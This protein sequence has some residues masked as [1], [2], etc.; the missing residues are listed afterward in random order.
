MVV[1]WKKLKKK[2]EKCSTFKKYFFWGLIQMSRRNIA[3]GI[4]IGTYQTK[5]VVVEANPKG[6]PT[7][8]GVGLSESKG[9]RHGYITNIQDAA[10]SI[11]AAISE[12]E[13]TS[14]LE[15]KEAYFSI[16][17]IGLG[18][19][20]SHG[21]TIISR[22]DLEVTRIDIDKAVQAS[23]TAIPQNMILNRRIVYTIPLAYRIDG[24]TSLG[25][26]EGSHGTKLE[27]KVL[28]IT[29]VENHFNNLILAAEEANISVLDV[30]ASP[31]A[32][33]IVTLNRAQKT[34]GCV[35]ANI[36]AETVSII[37][38]ENNIPISLEVFPIGSGDIT[39]DIALGLKITL[40]E[41]EQIKCGE[42]HNHSK[43]RLEEII[44]ARFSD[45]FELIEN[46]LKKIGKNGLLPAGIIL[47]GSGSN[48]PLATD[49][50]RV[51]LKLPSKVTGPLLG[52][53]VSDKISAKDP[54]WSVAYGLCTLGLYNE[55]T[56]TIKTGWGPKI[57]KPIRNKFVEWIKQ[58]LP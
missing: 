12:A 31:V 38:C 30:I 40:E 32:S 54:V 27:S 58:F 55:D 8:L 10:Q 50:A 28:F 16:G 17:G 56:G 25:D 33:S 36:G 9:V 35:L 57:I 20:I 47:T 18:S 44:V 13:K 34:A 52:A 22:A 29:C 1:Q 2:L 49:L 4:D 48:I 45:I 53:D 37:V 11:K 6:L 41:A 26:P 14:G 21:G 5:V 3:V 7:V 19:I 24:K 15:I 43:K 46:H 51:Y 23:E 42:P 39:N